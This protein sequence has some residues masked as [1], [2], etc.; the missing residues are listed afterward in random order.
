M[1]HILL[2]NVMANLEQMEQF[3]DSKKPPA[4]LREPLA[5]CLV[6]PRA[7]PALTMC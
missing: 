4:L 5:L 6:F 1:L 3:E 7:N 2:C